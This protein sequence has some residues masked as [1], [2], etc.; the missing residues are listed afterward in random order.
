MAVHINRHRED[1]R[2]LCR[3]NLWVHIYINAGIKS[4]SY[5]NVSLLLLFSSQETWL[6]PEPL[7]IF[8]SKRMTKSHQKNK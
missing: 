6:Y 1:E 7:A 5:P 3:V 4:L 2:W 8:A